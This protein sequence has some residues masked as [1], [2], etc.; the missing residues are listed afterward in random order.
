[1]CLCVCRHAF[2]VF[3]T[4]NV[5][6]PSVKP[7]RICIYSKYIITAS[8]VWAISQRG[9]RTVLLNHIISKKDRNKSKACTIISCVH[10]VM[11]ITLKSKA[12]FLSFVCINFLLEKNKD[13]LQHFLD[14]QHEGMSQDTFSWAQNWPLVLEALEK[15][16]FYLSCYSKWCHFRIMACLTH[17]TWSFSIVKFSSLQGGQPTFSE[18]SCLSATIN[19]FNVKCQWWQQLPIPGPLAHLISVLAPWYCFHWQWHKDCTCHPKCFI[20]V[21]LVGWCKRCNATVH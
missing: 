6:F 16:S 13:L 10:C 15:V 20:L 3:C 1:M 18:P 9:V 4:D 14:D 5:L 19:S 7:Y 11:R 2:A 17:C 12:L 8:K 21:W